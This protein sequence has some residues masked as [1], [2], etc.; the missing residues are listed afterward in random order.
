MTYMNRC[1]VVGMRVAAGIAAASAVA[2]AAS[3]SVPVTENGTAIGNISISTGAG[4]VTGNFTVTNTGGGASPLSISNQ[5]SAFGEDHYNWFQKCV[6]SN[7]FLGIA[8][9][10]KFVDPQSGG[11]GTLWAD[12]A[13][14][15]WDETAP[16]AM[17]DG[18]GHTAPPTYVPAAGH[19]ELGDQITGAANNILGFAD[20]PGSS[21]ANTL[22][23]TTIL[24]SVGPGN[25]YQPLAG[26]TWTATLGGSG[27]VISDLTAGAT[28]TAEFANEINTSGFGTWTQVPEPS[29]LGVLLAGL[30]LVRL[31]RRIA[32]S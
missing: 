26:F 10:G 12:T 18:A 9:G 32:T 23:F 24:M 13:P 7:A 15:Y 16:P 2:M 31:R 3:I 21:T 17:P 4:G 27:T 1:K 14:W 11:Q 6:V 30:V 8:A 25:K 22:N 29:S 5:A 20:F 28:F 19:T